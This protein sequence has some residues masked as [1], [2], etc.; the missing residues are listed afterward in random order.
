MSL[1]GR[2]VKQIFHIY[3]VNKANIYRKKPLFR[4]KGAF[5]L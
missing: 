5:L 2:K 1:Q 3:K 4:E